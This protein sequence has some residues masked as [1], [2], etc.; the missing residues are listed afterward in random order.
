MRIELTAPAQKDLETLEKTM[1][2]NPEVADLNLKKLRGKTD[3]WR[4]RVGDY[5][6]VFCMAQDQMTLRVIRSRH[7]REVYQD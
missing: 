4:L 5:R 6:V 1:Q 2:T 7:R 3:R